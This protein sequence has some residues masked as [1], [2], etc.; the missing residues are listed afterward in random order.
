MNIVIVNGKGQFFKGDW[1][2]IKWT[3]EF[4]NAR[5]YKHPSLAKKEAAK[6]NVECLPG[7]LPVKAIANYGMDNQKDL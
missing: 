4:P 2:T 6:L 1:A 7:D 5:V 3:D